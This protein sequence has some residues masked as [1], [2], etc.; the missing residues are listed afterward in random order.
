MLDGNIIL[1]V[2]KA[3]ELLQLLKAVV[4]NASVYTTDALKVVVVKYY[5][6]AVTAHRLTVLVPDDV[7]DHLQRW[8]RVAFVAVS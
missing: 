6:L 2:A 4:L 5:H 1:S 7:G 8:Q 3:M